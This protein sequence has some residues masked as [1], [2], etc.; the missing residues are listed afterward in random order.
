MLRR[1][2]RYALTALTVLAA[3]APASAQFVN[4]GFE[5]GALAPW[6]PAN[7]F[8]NVSSCTWTVT[9]ADAHT[10]TFSAEGSDNLELRQNFATPFA[11]GTVT[12]LT[13]WAKHLSAGVNALAYVLYYSNGSSS[14]NSV[15]TTGTDWN[16]FDV[17]SS[18]NNALSLSGFSVYGNTGG[19]TRVDDFSINGQALTATPEPATLALVGIGF[20]GLAVARRRRA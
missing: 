14:Q 5:T 2:I 9:N 6:F 15:N 3:A 13:F 4:P 19:I 16:M 8:C 12:S 11:P 7:N 18:V 20:V 10:G 17:T 1:P